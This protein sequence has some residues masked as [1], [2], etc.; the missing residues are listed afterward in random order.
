MAKHGLQVSSLN[1]ELTTPCLK[2]RSE[3]KVK[4]IQQRAFR[5]GFQKG[6]W[7]LAGQNVL[8]LLWGERLKLRP[9]KS[10]DPMLV[11]TR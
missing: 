2:S 11:Y 10:S 9:S 7:M 5:K 4:A 6:G 1:Q 3:S 8:V